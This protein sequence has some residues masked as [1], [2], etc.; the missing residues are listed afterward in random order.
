MKDILIEDNVIAPDTGAGI[1]IYSHE[2]GDLGGFAFD[3]VL[4][5]TEQLGLAGRVNIAHGKIVTEDGA[6]FVSERR[7]DLKPGSRADLVLINT[8]NPMDALV[9]RVP[10]P[11]RSLVDVTLQQMTYPS[12]LGTERGKPTIHQQAT[13]V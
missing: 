4:D 3:M 2:P 6:R 1:D 10:A 7:N 9:R 8:E 5:R 12:S 11:R 13:P